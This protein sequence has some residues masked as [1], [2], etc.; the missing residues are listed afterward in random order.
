MLPT[1]AVTF[2]KLKKLAELSLIGLRA[3]AHYLYQHKVSINWMLDAG[4]LMWS[5]H[6]LSTLM[7]SG[8]SQKTVGKS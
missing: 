3:S 5:I 2:T 6:K 7:A 1:A 4:L 8:Q